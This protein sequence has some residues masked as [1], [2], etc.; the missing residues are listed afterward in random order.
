MTRP[1]SGAPYASWIF[2][3]LVAVSPLTAYLWP[4]GFAAFTPI[5]AILLIPLVRASKPSAA[6]TA[7][8]LFLLYALAATLWSPVFASHGPVE[9]YADAERQTWGKLAMNAG[10]YAVLIGVAARLPTD[11]MRRLGLVF[12]IGAAVLGAVLLLEGL[13]GVRLYHVLSEALTDGIRPD[14]ERRNVAQA[15][16]ALALMYWPAV[17]LLRRRGW[18]RAAFVLTAAI[19]GAPILLNAWSPVAA[20]VLGG[21]VFWL[22]TRLGDRAGLVLG[23]VA[24][25]VVML[26][27]WAVLAAD[28][29][30]DWAS[31]RLGASWAARLDIWSFTA[32]QTLAHPLFG[33]GLDGSRAFLPFMLHPHSAPLQ[34]W[35][36]L[37][38]VGAVLF[39]GAWFFV[40]RAAGRCGPQGLAAAATYFVVGAL[41]FGV[42]QEWWLG[43]AAMTAIWVMLADARLTPNYDTM[44]E[45]KR[46]SA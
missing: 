27:P 37:G 33:W 32:E 11:A 45:A 3:A 41:S 6:W 19:V 18:T 17:T 39:A 29:L 31:G 36:E 40:C 35:L 22:A 10:L 26:A 34:V 4:F 12:M 7:L 14:L 9:D 24:A 44:I 28:G 1:E 38:L 5:A 13:W 42:W 8:L 46:L 21:L 25:G 16:Y 43:L 15:T 20:V 30:F 2:L 23:S